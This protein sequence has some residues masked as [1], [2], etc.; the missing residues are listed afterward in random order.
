MAPHQTRSKS[1]RRA[2]RQTARAC[3]TLGQ[4][5]ME[6]IVMKSLILTVLEKEKETKMRRAKNCQM[7]IIRT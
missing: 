6:R 4:K 3:R 7:T 5:V 1:A 2:A